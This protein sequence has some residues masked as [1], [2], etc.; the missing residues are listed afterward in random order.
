MALSSAAMQRE[1]HAP[2][3]EAE[4]QVVEMPTKEGG[5]QERVMLACSKDYLKK[6]R[7]LPKGMRGCWEGIYCIC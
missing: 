3:S 2:S 5:C 1:L 4:V 7:Q 6:R